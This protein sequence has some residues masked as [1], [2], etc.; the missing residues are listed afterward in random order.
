MNCTN[1]IPEQNV[2]RLG[3]TDTTSV[4]WVGSV[5][6]IVW[7]GLGLELYGLGWVHKN[8]PMS[9]SDI[10]PCGPRCGGGSPPY[11][12]L[13]WSHGSPLRTASQAR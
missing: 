7:V 11:T 8:G 10:A 3:Y 2:C 12:C 4:G 9:M 5:D 1:N 13:W 6:S